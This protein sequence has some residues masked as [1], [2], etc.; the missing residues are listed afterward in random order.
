MTDSF[1]TVLMKLSI[2]AGY[3][4]KAIHGLD[5]YHLMNVLYR[6]DILGSLEV[7]KSGLLVSG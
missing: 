3:C 5:S 1:K 6:S 7:V 4:R 2:P